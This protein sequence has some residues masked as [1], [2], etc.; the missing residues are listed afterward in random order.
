M[1]GQI[2]GSL[3]GLAKSYIDIKNSLQNNL[4]INFQWLHSLLIHSNSKKRYF[5][6]VYW[7]FYVR[8]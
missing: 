5:Y 7:K 3:G 1:I 8:Y 2:L 4:R 6:F